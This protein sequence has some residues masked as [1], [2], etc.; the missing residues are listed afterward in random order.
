MKYFRVSSEN[1]LS[2][3]KYI[4][5]TEIIMP[6]EMVFLA[7]AI[8]LSNED[9]ISLIQLAK[10]RTTKISLVHELSWWQKNWQFC[11]ES[12]I[13]FGVIQIKIPRLRN[14]E[15]YYLFRE[16][17]YSERSPELHSAVKALKELQ[18]ALLGF[19]I[20]VELVLDGDGLNSLFFAIK[21]FEEL[22]P[23]R[24]Y[25]DP[26]EMPLSFAPHI[27]A[28]FE[29]LKIYS[30][31]E[32]PKI[33]FSIH[34]PA[35]NEWNAATLNEFHGPQTI[36]I[37]LN[38]SCNHSCVFCG[39]HNENLS[40]EPSS[41]ELRSAKTEL[42]KLT[43]MKFPASLAK[44]IIESLP[45]DQIM[46][47]F[48]GAGE[49]LLH[50]SFLT[51]FN[52]VRERGF[53]LKLYTNLSTLSENDIREIHSLSGPNEEVSFVVNLSGA[54]ADV[55]IKT[56]PKQHAT[57]FY[58]IIDALEK[59]SVLKKQDGHGVHLTIMCVVNRMNYQDLPEFVKISNRLNATFYP[60]PLEIHG[61]KTLDL[62]ISD[63][64]KS[65]FLNYFH[66]M[67]NHA[68]ALKVPLVLSGEFEKLTSDYNLQNV[69]FFRKRSFSKRLLLLDTLR[70]SPYSVDLKY[71]HQRTISSPDDSDLSVPCYVG[72][73]Y[74]RI[75]ANG[76]AL[77]CC[78]STYSISKPVGDISMWEWWSSRA[79]S[80]FRT[81]MLTHTPLNTSLG[82]K[83][84][85]FCQQCTYVNY[86][87][88][89]DQQRR[90]IR[91]I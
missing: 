18:N 48:G 52:L 46:I 27:R 23:A 77:P 80:A 17:P 26:N 71:K 13:H 58:R 16:K 32:F 20:S 86:N 45:D 22:S 63:Q 62:L 39:L 67:L 68:K 83:E 4:I 29:N 49:P 42:R 85:A 59:F 19:S 10:K 47:I 88:E 5:T 74:I 2:L 9:L 40:P 79:I 30:Q 81:K 6:K 78:I 34:H 73:F 75:K 44:T 90:G 76:D 56:R 25:L 24:I 12:E 21:A 84:W 55:F 15:S 53:P 36:E 60:K 8:N 70:L 54:S 87:R 89:Y 72:Y 61:E 35:R 65:D 41:K 1:D 43:Q 28:Q 11:L 38:N 37:D 7:P 51:I 31:T 14:D 69:D 50:P 3:S 82:D 91:E 33:T 64:Q 66:S 57:D